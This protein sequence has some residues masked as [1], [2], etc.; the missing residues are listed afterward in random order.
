MIIHLHTD[1]K[2]QRSDSCTFFWLTA[3][4]CQKYLHENCLLSHLIIFSTFKVGFLQVWEYIDTYIE[5][6]DRKKLEI[7]TNLSKLM[8]KTC[9]VAKREL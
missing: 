1:E 5:G 2:L 6:F 9:A 3:V 8:I 7:I 4:L